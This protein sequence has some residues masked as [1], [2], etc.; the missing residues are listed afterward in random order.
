MGLVYTGL[1]CSTE[2]GVFRVRTGA[3]WSRAMPNWQMSWPDSNCPFTAKNRIFTAPGHWFIFVLNLCYDMALVRSRW[4][5]LVDDS[6]DVASFVWT[7]TI[8]M[9]H[10][11]TEYNRTSFINMCVFSLSCC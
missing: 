10:T 7:L 4:N 8:K 6:T 2:L 9:I 5:I 3:V 11:V 1:Q